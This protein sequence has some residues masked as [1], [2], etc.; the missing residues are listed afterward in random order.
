MMLMIGLK[1]F[2]LIGLAFLIGVIFLNTINSQ[3]TIEA[4]AVKSPEAKIQQEGKEIL[5]DAEVSDSDDEESESGATADAEQS[6]AD[7]SS[8][9]SPECILL[10]RK[11]QIEYED[12]KEDVRELE[13]ELDRARSLVDLEED[14]SPRD[15][16]K[17]NQSREDRERIEDELEEAQR[18]LR[19]A[20]L[21]VSKLLQMCGEVIYRG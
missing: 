10:S 15:E 2:L 1:G 8:A 9:P 3:K 6:E 12:A 16:A 13:R 14:R 4:V 19:E 5:V 7:A 20:E 17:L 18:V 21:E 11:A